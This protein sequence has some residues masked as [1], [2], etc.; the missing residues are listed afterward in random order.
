MK[1]THVSSAMAYLVPSITN[2]HDSEAAPLTCYPQ[3]YS[4]I[5][6]LRTPVQ[7]THFPLILV[8]HLNFWP[9]RSSDTWYSNKGQAPIKTIPNHRCLRD[10][11]SNAQPLAWLAVF[12][13]QA[14]IRVANK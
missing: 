1:D 3:N 5:L 9:W 6:R 11:H 8:S 4:Y 12:A 13:L 10:C 2:Q 14:Q 7:H